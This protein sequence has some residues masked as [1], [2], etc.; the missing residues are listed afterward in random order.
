MLESINQSLKAVTGRTDF[1]E[2]MREM[3]NKVLDNPQV[4]R[5]MDEHKQEINEEMI[6]RSL[7]KLYEFVQQNKSC[8]GCPSL[9]QCGNLLQGFTPELTLNGKTIDVRYDVCQTKRKADKEAKQQAMIKSMYMQKDLLKA[10]TRDL[11]G[12]DPSRRYVYK[13]LT[14]FIE[15]YK[16]DKKGKGI[17]L[18]GKFGVGKT[19]ILAAIANELADKNCSSMLVYVPEFTRE[20]KNS[21]KD[22]TTEEKLQMV[23]SAPIL[24]LDDIGAES[25]SSWVRDEVF[26]T[27]LQHRMSQQLPTFFS[28]NFTPDELEHHFTYS[29]RGEKEGVK[30]ARL[31]ERILYLAQPVKLDG[32]N[33]RKNN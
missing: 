31:M 6:E 18:H 4:K 13:Q 16:K 23:K 27:I 15:N 2:R 8:E 19:F 1:K 28:S 25:M 10:T 24:M 3:K 30:A 11:D 29:Q 33:R 20:L 9:E 22:Q 17:Y 32:E 5:F 12:T 14:A 7:N 21:L 26:G